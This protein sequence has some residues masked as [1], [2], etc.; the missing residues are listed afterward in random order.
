VKLDGKAAV[1]T[2][3]AGG[4]GRAICREFLKEGARVA[5]C[6][7]DLALARQAADAMGAKPDCIR[8]WA[9]DVGDSPAVERAADEIFA[10]FGGID[11]WVNNAGISFVR[12]FLE[13]DPGLWE[14]T[15]RVNLTGA[16]NGCRAA[17]RHMLPRGRGVVLNMSSQSGKQGNAQYAAYCASKF[18]VI[19]LTQSLA[20]EFAE[21]N[22]RVNALCPGIV[23]TGL[24]DNM[25]PDY[26]AKRGLRKEDVRAYLEQKIP[27]HRL[28]SENDVARLAVFLASDD[29]A[30]MTGQSINLSGGSVM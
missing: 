25:L 27:M 3:G 16:F 4:I 5:L 22:I 2:G 23:F 9:F 18:G 1:V 6:D 15:L 14:K 20:M 17:I 21:R 11:V 12:P 19:G 28:C 29:A 24:W 7:L 30:Y 10:F 13:C 8:A 26:A